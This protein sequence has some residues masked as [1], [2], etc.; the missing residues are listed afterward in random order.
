VIGRRE[1]ALE[2]LAAFYRVLIRPRP[3]TF[4]EFSQKARGRF[5]AGIVWLVLT[6][7]AAVLLPLAAGAPFDPATVLAG[8][9]VLPLGVMLWAAAVD[10]LYRRIY[11]HQARLYNALFYCIVCVFVPTTILNA[12]LQLVPMVSSVADWLVPLAQVALVTMAVI[13]IT[14]LRLWQAILLVA[15]SAVTALVASLLL[16]L[17]FARLL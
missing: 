17:L 9:V 11:D 16:T 14:R 12:L 1:Q 6:A 7:L 4:V 3:S 2:W 5:E 13:A 15:V 8:V 10:F